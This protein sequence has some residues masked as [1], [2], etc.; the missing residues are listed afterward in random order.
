MHT[1]KA[2]NGTVFNSNADLS[3]L[4]EISGGAISTNPSTFGVD[5]DDLLEFVAEYV[6]NQAIA[7]IEDADTEALLQMRARPAMRLQPVLG[8][9]TAVWLAWPDDDPPRLRQLPAVYLV[10]PRAPKGGWTIVQTE[11]SGERMGG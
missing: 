7:E 9:P 11:I 5:G 10:E 4:V 1:Y 3:G 2:T 8:Q 6:R